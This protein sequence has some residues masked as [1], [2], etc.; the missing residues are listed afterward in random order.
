MT[1]RKTNMFARTAGAV[2]LAAAIW[3]MTT[4]PLGAADQDPGACA[5]IAGTYVTIFTDR[6]GV[7]S[8]RGLMTFTSDGVLLV[9]DSAQGGVPGVWDPFSAA[10]GAWSCVAAD[11]GKLSVSA[12]GLNFVL[13]T[14]GRTPAFARVDYQASLEVKTGMLSGSATLRIGSGQ[15]L[16][17]AD[18]VARPG[19]LVD[20]FHFD[21]AR[22]V[23]K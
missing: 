5:G 15:D 12:M 17:G 21:G 14:D 19:R 22:V 8:S 2:G 16:E 9:T 13:P 18:P 4:G 23:V 6:E 10:H 1:T 3:I 7:F 20:E 11:G